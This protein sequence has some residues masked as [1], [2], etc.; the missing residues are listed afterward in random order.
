MLHTFDEIGPSCDHD[1]RDFD[2][3]RSGWNKW[4]GEHDGP[5]LAHDESNVGPMKGTNPHASRI[6]VTCDMIEAVPPD[7]Q[8]KRHSTLRSQ[9]T[10]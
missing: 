3:L 6:Q 4:R 10:R 8:L 7:G 1:I 9:I 2:L 5:P